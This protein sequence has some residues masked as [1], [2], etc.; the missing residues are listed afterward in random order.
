MKPDNE[1]IT[2]LRQ[3]VTNPFNKRHFPR[4]VAQRLKILKM[5]EK[6]NDTTENE[7][8]GVL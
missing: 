5:Y 8:F 4:C 6:P 7:G 1:I 3:Y 2:R